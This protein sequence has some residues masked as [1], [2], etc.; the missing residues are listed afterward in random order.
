MKG[1]LGVS[2]AAVATVLL[3]PQAMADVDILII[4]GEVYDGTG[5]P[6]KNV[7]VGITADKIVYVGTDKPKAKSIVNAKGMA[8]TPGFI[9]SHNHIPERADDGQT[10]PF[11]REQ[12]IR[13]GITTML[14]GPDGFKSAKNVRRIAD[15][16]KSRGSSF[17]YGCYVGFNDVRKEVMGDSQQRR[18]TAAELE[19]MKVEVRAGMDYGCAGLSTGLMYYPGF[20]STTEE[21]VAL[22]KEVKKYDGSYDSH[23]RDPFQ[24]WL[25]TNKE[26]LEIGRQAGIRPK[27]GHEKPMG[28]VN[29]GKSGEAIRLVED[30]R[31]RGVDAVAD[32]YPYMGA[33]TFTLRRLIIWPTDLQVNSADDARRVAKQA[34]DDPALKRRLQLATEYGIDGGYSLVQRMGGPKGYDTIR[35]VQAPGRPDLLD[36]KLEDVAREKS[37]TPFET[38]LDLTA[39][40]AGD[41]ALQV[42][43]I[44]D[45]ADL[46]NILKQPWTMIATDASYIERGDTTPKSPGHPRSTGTYPRVFA[47]Y[48]R[49]MKV[50]TMAEAVYKMTGLP[51][52]HLHYFDRGRI[53][54]GL[55]ADIV[56]F[57]PNKIADKSTYVD[58][59]AQ[60][61]GMVD[62]LVNGA[63]VLKDGKLTG[64]TPGS[65]VP[66]S[67]R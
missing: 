65:F 48:V 9:D 8:V 29:R 12:Q 54:E 30:Y 10:S 28:P 43:S 46:I 5:A 23:T 41:V 58:P 64:A 40:V 37:Q 4:G 20:Y 25:G 27:I 19:K 16:L 56:V 60:S 2:L 61:V 15:A 66:M 35:I 55:V 67:K 6:G 62:V 24:D 31:A 52:Q 34:L 47:R 13:Q 51:A 11:Y 22:A 45:E 50:L 7:N 1:V 21:V 39:N 33:A 14:I 17:N 26:D 32:Q 59:Y 63:F 42:G 18:P 36:R 44:E 38:V 3:A 53:A 49:D 57:D